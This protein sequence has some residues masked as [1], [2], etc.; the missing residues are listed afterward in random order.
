MWL[1]SDKVKPGVIFNL[2]V[3]CNLAFRNLHI[4]PWSKSESVKFVHQVFSPISNNLW[5]LYT[6][7]LFC[8]L[9]TQNIFH[10]NNDED[11]YDYA[12]DIFGDNDEEEEDTYDEDEEDVEDCDEVT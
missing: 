2:K 6:P 7:P 4:Q 11:D 8:K 12:G 5:I 9:H 1:T 10:L 3:W